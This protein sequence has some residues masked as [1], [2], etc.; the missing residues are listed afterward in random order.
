MQDIEKTEQL[1]RPKKRK[2]WRTIRFTMFSILLFFIVLLLI[3]RLSVVQTYIAGKYSDYL[4]KKTHTEIRIGRIDISG[5]LNVKIYDL[6]VVDQEDTLMIDSKS[7]EIDLNLAALLKNRLHVKSIQIDS[8][9]FALMEDSRD[10]EFSLMKLVDYFLSDD[11]STTESNIEISVDR[12]D[13]RNS[14]YRMDLWST[15]NFDEGGMN[16]THLDIDSINLII[17]D[18]RVE[19]DTLVGIMEK[20]TAKDKCGFELSDF[21]G[22]IRL[23]SK[24]IDIENFHLKAG[25]SWAFI[26]DYHMIYKRWPDWLDFITNVKFKASIDSAQLNLDD[27]KYFATSMEGMLDTLLFNG[28]IRGPISKLKLRSGS[29]F[30]KEKSHFIGAIDNA[31]KDAE[32]TWYCY[33]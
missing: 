16:Y 26:P 21:S 12:L 27:I 10:Q 9:Y 29:V 17:T 33:H 23:S 19:A 5:L 6:Y 25:A 7:I 22:N 30:F 32:G 24:G 13:I 15:S 1:P 3:L 11:T 20:L 8:T 31:V 14:H 4:S 2:L 28:N 18:F